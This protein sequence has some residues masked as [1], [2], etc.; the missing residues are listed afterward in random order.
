MNLLWLINLP[1]LWTGIMPYQFRLIILMSNQ[2]RTL[3][4]VIY[5]SENQGSIFY[6]YS[7]QCQFPLFHIFN[8]HRRQMCHNFQYLDI[9]LS[10]P[11]KSIAVL[12]LKWIR[13]RIGSPWMPIPIRQNDA[14]PDRIHN[15]NLTEPTLLW[16]DPVNQ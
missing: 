3:L 14:D 8:F 2:I 5:R 16:Q 15:L 13:I 10:F 9:I 1:V 11:E 7:K 4:Q 6:F 12:W